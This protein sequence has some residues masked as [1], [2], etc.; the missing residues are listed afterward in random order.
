[1][2]PEDT[3][4]AIDTNTKDDKIVAFT[5]LWQD[6]QLYNGISFSIGRVE[7]VGVVQKYRNLGLMPRIMDAVH[8]ASEIRGD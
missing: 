5:T 1:M 4:F 2:T 3:I 6:Q 7:F 8:G